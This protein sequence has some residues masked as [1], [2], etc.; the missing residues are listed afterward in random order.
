M[1]SVAQYDSYGLALS[2]P[3][4]T[5]SGQPSD[6]LIYFKAFYEPSPESAI[7]WSPFAD[8][9]TG[10]SCF[11]ARFEAIQSELASSRAS[12]YSKVWYSYLAPRDLHVG[13]KSC[14]KLLPSTEVYSPQYVAR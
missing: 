13:L 14:S 8:H 1:L 11:L 3:Q 2:C 7:S 4:P 12:E 10:P 5:T 6:F 9:L